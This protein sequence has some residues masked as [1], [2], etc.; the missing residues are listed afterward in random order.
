MEEKKKDVEQQELTRV[1]EQ[2]NT[3]PSKP[4]SKT[5]I[6]SVLVKYAVCFCVASLITF[7][8]FWIKGF[9]T[10]DVGV[11]LQILSD[12]FVVSGLLLTMFAGMIFISG[13]GG[14]IGISFVMRTV[15]QAFVPMGRKHHETYKK[16]RE[17]KL[18]STK[19]TSGSSIFLT[20]LFFLLIG[21]I[22]TI[23]WYTNFYNVNL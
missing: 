19:K 6:K 7:I 14:L 10:D 8:V 15:V 1:A 3:I 17:R 16:Y 13:E 9:F 4:K 12:G 23:I 11:N 5:E 20:G 22:F 2:Q 21:I 18:G